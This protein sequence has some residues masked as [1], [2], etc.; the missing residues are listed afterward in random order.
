MCLLKSNGTQVCCISLKLPGFFANLVVGI[1]ATDN[2]GST[3]TPDCIRAMYNI[4]VGTLS[5]PGN[6]LGL[7]ELTGDSYD[8][9]DLDLFFQTFAP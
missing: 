2:C 8:Q 9:S 4:P 1:D 6:T 7:L 5:Q 3:I